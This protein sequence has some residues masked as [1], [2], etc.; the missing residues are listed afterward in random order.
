M[1]ELFFIL[2]IIALGL[3]LIL[4]IVYLHVNRWSR[5]IKLNLNYK[6]NIDKLFG[7]LFLYDKKKVY[8]NITLTDDH[9]EEFK[10]MSTISLPLIHRSNNISGGYRILFDMNDKEQI[11]SKH[12]VQP[13]LIKGYFK[14][15]HQTGPKLGWFSILLQL[16]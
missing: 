9:I 13:N 8:I 12:F 2:L 6:V 11:L 10:S 4:Y 1:E 7:L 15:I 3:N 14:V 16:Q 5:K